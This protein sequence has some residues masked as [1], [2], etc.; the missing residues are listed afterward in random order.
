MFI[1]L[2]HHGKTRS[3]ANIPIFNFAINNRAGKQ[4]YN[5]LFK[6]WFMVCIR[7]VFVREVG[8]A[9]K[10][11]K[12]YSR[13]WPSAFPTSQKSISPYATR[14]FKTFRLIVRLEVLCSIDKRS[15][16]DSQLEAELCQILCYNAFTKLQVNL[17]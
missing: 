12:S 11:R 13:R 9:W 1:I 4:K 2:E 14:K 5:A 17:I 3:F 16:Y 10:K 6:N 15:T 8:R 7:G